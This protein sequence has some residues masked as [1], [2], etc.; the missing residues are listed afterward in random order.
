MSFIKTFL[1]DQ[2]NGTLEIGN[3]YFR[4]MK[5]EKEG[6]EGDNLNK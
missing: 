5:R 2:V 6:M 4:R 1:H 3:A